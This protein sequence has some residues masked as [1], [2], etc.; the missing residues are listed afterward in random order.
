MSKS[1]GDLIAEHNGDTFGFKVQF[2]AAG[3][4]PISIGGEVV[5]PTWKDAVFAEGKIGVPCQVPTDTDRHILAHHHLLGHE[6]AQALRWWMHAEMGDKI[7]TRLMKYRI[8]YAHKSYREGFIDEHAAKW[9]QEEPTPE[10]SVQ[11]YMDQM[12]NVADLIAGTGWEVVRERVSGLEGGDE[13][14]GPKDGSEAD[15]VSTR[16]EGGRPNETSLDPSI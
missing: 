16:P 8:E 15:P 14:A 6:A 1:K 11:T 13:G 2:R 5:Y 7:R 4:A 12:K 9:P 10:P 3:D